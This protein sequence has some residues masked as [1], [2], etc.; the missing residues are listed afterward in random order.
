MKN[1]DE[2]VTNFY[3]GRPYSRWWHRRPRCRY[4]NQGTVTRTEGPSRGQAD[5]R[6]GR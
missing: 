4:Q 3:L 2:I 6:L 1:T 5:D